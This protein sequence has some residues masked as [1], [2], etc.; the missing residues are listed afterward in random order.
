MSGARGVTEVNGVQEY[1]YFAGGGWR[2]AN[3]NRLFE[4]LN[5]AEIFQTTEI[6]R[7]L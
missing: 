5:Q 7:V 6:L 3:E 2:A 1:Q 4:I